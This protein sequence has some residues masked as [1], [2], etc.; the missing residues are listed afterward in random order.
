MRAGTPYSLLG[1]G[2]YFGSGLELVF[3]GGKPYSEVS[4]RFVGDLAGVDC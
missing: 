1:G 4:D 3:L 2:A